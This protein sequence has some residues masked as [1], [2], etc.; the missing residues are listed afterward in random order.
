M[1]R[2]GGHVYDYNRCGPGPFFPFYFFLL[3]DAHVLGGDVLSFKALGVEGCF[4]RGGGAWHSFFY[5]S[6]VLVEWR[7]VV[8]RKAG[9]FAPIWKGTGSF[10]A[11]RG[12]Y[13]LKGSERRGGASNIK[14]AC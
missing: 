13:L 7:W 6:L 10:W 4:A 11:E 14:G 1:A 8:S 9:R 3:H 5:N 12:I 2:E